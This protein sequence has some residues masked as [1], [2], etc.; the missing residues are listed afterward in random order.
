M[1]GNARERLAELLGG[2]TSAGTF[3]AQLEAPAHGLGL[4][5]A[6]VGPVNLP[7]RA[8]QAKK[9]IVVARPALFGRA[10]KR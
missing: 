9:L 8:P 1:A 4:E 2:S 5:V 6:G 7:L 3:S 10:R